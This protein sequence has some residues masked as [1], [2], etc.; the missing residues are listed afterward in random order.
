MF[1]ID[2]VNIDHETVSGPNEPIET[3]LIEAGIKLILLFIIQ[4]YLLKF[5]MIFSTFKFKCSYKT[6][7]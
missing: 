2:D 4:F 3:V 1:Y 5:F 7:S 6:W